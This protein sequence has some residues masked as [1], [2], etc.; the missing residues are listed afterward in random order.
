MAIT[1]ADA[2]RTE[3]LLGEL[4]LSD[5]IKFDEHFG[6]IR[7]FPFWRTPRGRIRA[8]EKW[9]DLDEQGKIDLIANQEVEPPSPTASEQ[10]YINEFLASGEWVY[11]RV[12]DPSFAHYA[13]KWEYKWPPD[14]TVY[15]Y[16]NV[17]TDYNIIDRA[18]IK[19]V[20]YSDSE[21]STD[22]REHLQDEARLH[23]KL[24]DLGCAHIIGLRS[25]GDKVHQNTF[26]LYMDYA[27]GGDLWQIEKRARSNSKQIPEMY[28]WIIFD[29]LAE[30][31]YVLQNGHSAQFDANG[32]FIPQEPEPG[33]DS[34]VHRDIKPG[35]IFLG[36]VKPPYMGYLTPML[37]DFGLAVES[38]DDEEFK[39]GAG[40]RGWMAPELQISQEELLEKPTIEQDAVAIRDKTDIWALGLVMWQLMRSSSY[41]A[42]H[43]QAIREEHLDFATPE[44]ESPY[45][46]EIVDDHLQN[47]REMYST[48]LE[49]Q[50]RMCVEARQ[51][52]RPDISRLR[53]EVRVELIRA[54]GIFGDPGVAD[55]ELLMQHLKVRF[56]DDAFGV[57]VQGP[58]RKRRRLTG[59]VGS[60]DVVGEHVGVP[61]EEPKT[62]SIAAAPAAPPAPAPAPLAPPPAPPPGPPASWPKAAPPTNRDER[63][64]YSRKR[65]GVPAAERTGFL[66][67][68]GGYRAGRIADNRRP[69]WYVVFYTWTE[70]SLPQGTKANNI[71]I[72][73]AD[74]Q[75]D[76]QRYSKPST[77]S[78]SF[79]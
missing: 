34:I 5:R 69:T 24:S 76:E 11:A 26:L 31:L 39:G 30:A 48:T 74:E 65:D 73:F 8:L 57:G 78:L 35:N 60:A 44:L 37:G 12:L 64:F 67:W 32:A 56:R 25:S 13:E 58:P 68:L 55:P 22:T 33:W 51:E 79:G 9:I 20:V 14:R 29:A 75:H 63:T 47:H 2:D 62:V 66:W 71:P 46:K 40:T 53:R 70:P 10:R 59:G 50:V 41:P 77:P 3:F 15:L 4:D 18:A 19:R 43:L 27:P 36:D 54:K 49:R 16:I 38:T 1:Q 42:E 6:R 17:D 28:L 23:K 72:P 52:N 45:A 61:A 7:R 21:G